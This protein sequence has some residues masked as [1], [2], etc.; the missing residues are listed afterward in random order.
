MEIEA[1]DLTKKEKSFTGYLK[2]YLPIIH[3]MS[4]EEIVKLFENAKKLVDLHAKL[5]DMTDP[6]ALIDKI[7]ELQTKNEY[8]PSKEI[9]ALTKKI[10]D[11]KTDQKKLLK[12]L[13]TQLENDIGMD[14]S[15]QYINKSLYILEGFK[16]DK[17][18]LM[19]YVTNIILKG[20]GE[21]VISE[22]DLENKMVHFSGS[23]KDEQ[24]IQEICKTINKE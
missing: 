22:L 14:I 11:E 3:K 6:K 18:K 2:R 15:P 9:D 4:A 20:A 13:Q 7:K 12:D 23:L 8:P 17:K 21:G 19:Q 10:G 5:K 24:L 16:T 1:I